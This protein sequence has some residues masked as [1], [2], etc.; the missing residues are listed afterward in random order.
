MKVEGLGFKA[1]L[2]V[3]FIES[4][5]KIFGV[6]ANE[7]TATLVKEHDQNVLQIGMALNRC[8]YLG[9]WRSYYTSSVK[10]ANLTY[11]SVFLM[12]ILNPQP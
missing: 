9:L 6:A 1:G 2:G 11:T 12:K 5:M 8:P 3:G 7:R 4:G 10:A